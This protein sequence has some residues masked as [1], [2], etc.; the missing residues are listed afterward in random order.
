MSDHRIGTCVTGGACVGMSARVRNISTAFA[1]A[2][3]VTTTNRRHD[4]GVEW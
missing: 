3:S 2:S 4:E 1:D